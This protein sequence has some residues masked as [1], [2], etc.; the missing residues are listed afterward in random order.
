[1]VPLIRLCKAE[2]DILINL[3][4]KESCTLAEPTKDG[5]G[6]PQHLPTEMLQ[7]KPAISG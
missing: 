3:L 1:M 2:L 5:S 7:V 6:N 4:N